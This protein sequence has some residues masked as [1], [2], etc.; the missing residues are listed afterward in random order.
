MLWT[1]T[2]LPFVRFHI[3]TVLVSLYGFYQC[4]KITKRQKDG[5]YSVH[6]RDEKF[7]QNFDGNELTYMII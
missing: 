7:L 3:A 6:E 1:A 5:T 4:G 2:T